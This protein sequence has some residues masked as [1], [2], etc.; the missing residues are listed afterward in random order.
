MSDGIVFVNEFDRKYWFG[1]VKRGSFLDTRS[2][3][4]HNVD[5]K[6]VK[7]YHLPRVSSLTNR[8][9]DNAKRQFGRQWC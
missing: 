5:T 9:G 3:H 7:L 6:S 8:F 1:G 4:Y 2:P